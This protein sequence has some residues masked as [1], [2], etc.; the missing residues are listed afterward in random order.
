VFDKNPYN[1]VYNSRYKSMEMLRRVTAFE[2][3]HSADRFRMFERYVFG[4][5]KNIN[6][7]IQEVLNTKLH[8]QKLY[9]FY[10]NEESDIKEIEWPKNII[11]L[12]KQVNNGLNKSKTKM[13]LF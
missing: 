10:F 6:N 7:L 5:V 9:N 1:R 13:K 3:F 4:K 11:G 12:Q 8:Y 2:I